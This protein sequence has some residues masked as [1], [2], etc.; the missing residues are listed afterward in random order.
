MKNSN[1]SNYSSVVEDDRVGNGPHVKEG[2]PAQ[3]ADRIKA[4]VLLFH[5]DLDQ[6][7][8][9]NQSKMMEDKLKDAGKA[10]TFIEYEGLAHS[11]QN[12]ASRIDMLT[13]SAAFL[14]K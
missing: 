11:L 1:N 2:S 13:R 10:V 4:P 7:V 5:G 9:I 8:L 14:P 3:N 6:N 12:S